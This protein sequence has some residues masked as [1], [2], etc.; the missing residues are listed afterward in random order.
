M[1]KKIKIAWKNNFIE[2]N[3]SMLFFKHFFWSFKIGRDWLVLDQHY[4]WGFESDNEILV[5]I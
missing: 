1:N 5:G 2:I 3:Q 4:I